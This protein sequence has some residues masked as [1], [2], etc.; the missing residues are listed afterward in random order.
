MAR[1]TPDHD[2]ARDRETAR[3][4]R[5]TRLLVLL[6]AAWAWLVVRALQGLPPVPALPAVD[7]LYVVPVLFFVALLLIIVGTQVGSARSPHLVY[8]PEQVDVRLDEVIGIDPIVED[9]RRSLD[10]FWAHRTF[11]DRTGGRPRRGLL[12]EGAPGTGKTLTAKAMAAEAG[13]PF[14]FVSATSFQSMYYGAT[15]RK[16][17]AYFRA[18]RKAA[19]KE[20]GAIGF[21]EEIDAIAMARGFMPVSRADALHADAAGGGRRAER[22]TERAVS[23]GTGGGLNEL[24][25]Q[26]QSFDEP[27]GADKMLNRLAA[28]V[29]LLLPAT[30]QIPMRRPARVPLLLIAATNRADALDPAL[31][32]PGRFDRRLTFPEPD[33]HGRRALINHFLERRAHTDELDETSLRDRLAAATNG[34]TPVMIEHVLDEAL[35]NAM[36]RGEDAMSF[37]D[38]EKARITEMVGLGQPVT[39][40]RTEQELI[41]THEA[42]HAVVAH[43]VA[44]QR[45]LEVVTIVKRGS[46]LGLL[47]HDD[48]EDVYTRSSADLRALIQISMGGWC[49]EELFFGDTSTGPASD[50]AAATRLAAQMVGAAGMTG[51]LVSLAATGKDIVEAVVGDT[52]ARERLEQVLTDARD[53]VRVLLADNRDLVEALRDALLDRYELVGPE[54]TEVLYLAVAAREPIGV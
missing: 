14:L 37:A 40:T 29:N 18:L 21:I 15:A 2:I 17:R 50:L 32:R 24:L 6:L 45:V 42:G 39:Y 31:L 11:A 22:A 48:A 10:L 54:I 13:V 20:G 35:V 43:L 52:T 5:L 41:A 27:L 38:V 1:T 12:F 9:V 3:R 16:I 19:A 30:R 7:P 51:S 23:E 26:M 34:W 25:V 53:A 46:A 36:R 28:A 49:A 33:V 8:R 44:P 47:A 4:R